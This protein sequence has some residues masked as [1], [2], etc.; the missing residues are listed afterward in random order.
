MQA[1]Y[2]KSY[3]KIAIKSKKNIYLG[4]ILLLISCLLLFV[5][6]NKKLGE[7]AT[8]WESYHESVS[9]NIKYF[10]LNSLKEKKYQTTYNNLNKQSALLAQLEN[11][12]VF[13]NPKSYFSSSIELINTML[14]GY[15]NN[16]KG[17]S[18]LTIMS[19]TKLYQLR[20]VYKYLSDNN[21]P[22]ALS[23]TKSSTYLI[24]LLTILGGIIYFLIVLLV[25]DVWMPQIRHATILHNVPYQLKTRVIGVNIVTLAI[26][27]SEL[28]LSLLAAFLL[29]GLKNGFSTIKYPTSVYFKDFSALPV[30]LYVIL[31]IFY[32]AV[33]CVFAT[34]LAILLNKITK[35]IYLT[36]FVSL[37]MYFL[38][39]IPSKWIYLLPAPYLN[40]TN[41]YNGQLATSVNTLV[42]LNFLAGIAIL[43]IWSAIIMMTYLL[44]EKK[45]TP[46]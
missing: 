4:L 8:S 14:E 41:V 13:D 30:W 44:V 31:F 3:F 10:Q 46:R 29:A 22:I 1:K 32:V 33:V 36:I 43:L 17:A 21:I 38:S 7:G 35:N 24:Y 2:L 5:V 15:K 37:G 23:S 45:V 25:S 9:Q 12:Q 19:K 34:N 28:L 6:E 27:L 20:A 26:T 40:I 11:S 16:Y 42:P 39:Y 18:S